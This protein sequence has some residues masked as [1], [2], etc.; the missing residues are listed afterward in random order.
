MGDCMRQRLT[1]LA[2]AAAL[3]APVAEAKEPLRLS[4][5][6]KWHVNYAPD[7]C[8]LARSFGAGDEE[9][10]LLLDRFQPGP[11]VYMTLVGKPLRVRSD[12]RRITLRFGPDD[13]PFDKQFESAEVEG[14]K[15]ALVLRGG[16]FI[17][18]YDPAWAAG[19]RDDDGTRP[20]PV[21]DPALYDAIDHLELR[22]PGK[23]TMVL[24]TGS[25]LAAE[26]TLTA[27][28]DDLLRGW[29]IDVAAHRTL[30]RRAVP[31]G[32]PGKWMNSSDYPAEMRRQGYQGLVFFRLVVDREGK[33]V[34]CHI[35]QST[36]PQAFDDAVCKGIMARASFAPALDAAGTPIVSYYLNSVFFK[37]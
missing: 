19:E 12:N 2:L 8:R 28:T 29:G 23:Q 21:V 35:Q 34:S 37:M 31:V 5:S 10:V 25:M 22:I 4:P 18:G 15:A 20:L 7:S 14:G 26:R 24:E 16:L 11:S 30:S 13:P 3:V 27:C 33:P 36:R 9:V 1:V 32:A 6:S 17:T